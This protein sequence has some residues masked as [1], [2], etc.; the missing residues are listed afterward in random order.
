MHARTCC[1]TLREGGDKKKTKQEKPE[2]MR[3]SEREIWGGGGLREGK[4][5]G[6][7]KGE[8]NVMLQLQFWVD[9]QKRSRTES[10]RRGETVAVIG[11]HGGRLRQ[12]RG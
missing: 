12:G 6:C 8:K 2:G 7:G 9:S 4:D 3:E 11:A 5:R 10:E 1:E